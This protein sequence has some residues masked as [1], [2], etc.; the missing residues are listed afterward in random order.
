MAD[1]NEFNNVRADRVESNDNTVE[2]KL[3]LAAIAEG[4]RVEKR[5]EAGGDTSKRKETAKQFDEQLKAF[6]DKSTDSDNIK[7]LQDLVKKFNDNPNK[8]DAIKQVATS[9]LRLD[10][11]M[12]KQSG[13]TVAQIDQARQEELKNNPAR[14]GMEEDYAS[15]LDQFFDRLT[16]LSVADRDKIETALERKANEPMDQRDARVRIAIGSDQESLAKFDAMQSAYNTLD[17]VKSPQ[18]KQLEAKH[19]GQILEFRESK[20]V[21]RMLVMR[22]RLED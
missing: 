2:Q 17:S 21:W 15:K 14:V 18:E 8:A 11:S 16:S 4:E 6:A 12:G 10:V 1:G 13:E 9:Y 20:A 7:Q 22:S 3:T 5:A 19:Y